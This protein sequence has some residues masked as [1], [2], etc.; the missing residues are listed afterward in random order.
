[1][2]FKA[3]KFKDRRSAVGF[4]FWVFVF[5]CWCIIYMFA[6]GFERWYIPE[7]NKIK[8]YEGIIAVKEIAVKE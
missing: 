4:I 5:P 6:S 8:S 1:M 7:L 3:W 2:Q